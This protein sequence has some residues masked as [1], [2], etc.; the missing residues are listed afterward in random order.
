MDRVA[1]AGRFTGESLL[2]LFKNDPKT[3]IGLQSEPHDI[4]YAC[5]KSGGT[6]CKGLSYTALGMQGAVDAVRSTGATNVVSA[7]GIDY[8]N[9]LTGWLANQSLS[10]FIAAEALA[11][12]SLYCCCKAGSLTS[13]NA[14]SAS[15]P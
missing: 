11:A 7:S 12:A 1:T 15:L 14:S 8:A 10:F 5:W 6:A 3:F 2:T 13:A 9:N 4:T